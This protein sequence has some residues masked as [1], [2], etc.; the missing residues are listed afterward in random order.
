VVPAVSGFSSAVLD[1]K[2]ALAKYFPGEAP[3]YASME[4]FVAANIL[5]DALKRTGPQLDTERLVDALESTR[6]L[7]LGLGVSLNFGRSDHQASHKI[8][9]TALDEA[10]RFQPLEL[11]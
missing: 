3:D 7:D 9:G 6:N 5:I 11:E 1:Y 8:W 4:G 2:N 10:G